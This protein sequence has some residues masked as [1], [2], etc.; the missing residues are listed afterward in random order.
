MFDAAKRV[1]ANMVR[2]SIWLPNHELDTFQDDSYIAPHH[3]ILAVL[4]DV[5]IKVILDDHRL[6]VERLTDV[7]TRL[8]T[9]RVRSQKTESRFSILKKWI[10]LT[11]VFYAIDSKYFL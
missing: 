11:I 3:L 1:M 2:A 10:E 7:T 6:K 8:R 4:E 9:R 5:D